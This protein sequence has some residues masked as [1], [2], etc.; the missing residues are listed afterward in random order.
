ML[1]HL[2]CSLMPLRSL[3]FM[4]KLNI[5][6]NYVRDSD[7]IRSCDRSANAERWIA[8]YFKE[9][10]ILRKLNVD[11]ITYSTNGLD[12]R[13]SECCGIFGSLSCWICIGRVLLNDVCDDDRSSIVKR[14][15][16]SDTER[17]LGIEVHHTHRHHHWSILH[18]GRRIWRLDDVDRH[19]RRV[20][21]HSN[22]THPDR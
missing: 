17:I 7:D 13:L 18:Q 20:S 21:F 16:C 9:S 12:L 19:D 8:R 3:P 15:P 4:Q 5:Q 10:S 2:D 6:S 22:P 11:Y 1:L 14:W